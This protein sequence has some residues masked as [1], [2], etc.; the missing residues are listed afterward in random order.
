MKILHFNQ[1]DDGGA[2]RAMMRLHQGLRADNVESFAFVQVKTSDDGWVSSPQTLIGKLSAK[3]KL[4]EHISHLP[5]RLYQ[6]KT[7]GHFSPSFALESPVT[8]IKACDPDIIH[9]HWINHGFINIEAL[10]K[11]NKPIVW[12]LHDMWPFTGGCHYSNE[13]TAYKSQCGNC[14]ALGS[15]KENDLSRT[16]WKRK[17]KA[18]KNLN[19]TIAAPSNWMA[20][21][22]RE[23]SLFSELPIEVIP[24]GLDTSEFKP[25]DKKMARQLMNLPQDKHL[26]LFGA[27]NV[28]DVRKGMHLLLPALDKLHSNG[29]KDKIELMV[30]GAAS[31][32]MQDV[33]FKVNSL[34]RLNDNISLSLAYS[35]ADVFIAPSLEDNL[36]N[37]LVE[38]LACGTPGVA[39]N[40][41]GIPDIID[42]K[43]NG[44]LATPFEPESLAEGIQWVLQA[45]ESQALRTN[46]HQKA[47]QMFELLSQARHY[48][49]LYNTILAKTNG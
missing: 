34:G 41:G 21:C 37:T 30:F 22:A 5:L 11:L 20:N 8:A 16:I 47:E 7:D 3:L 26:V 40:V 36:P 44:Y 33:E 10:A 12:T 31:S 46:S 39:F 23:S 35:A 13:C 2:G 17:S 27:A 32:Q 45:D 42:H 38:S 28:Q 9:L 4:S 19:L 24:N 1:R 14:P 29:L 15:Q 49:K 6:D 25:V 43:H 48:K 18:W